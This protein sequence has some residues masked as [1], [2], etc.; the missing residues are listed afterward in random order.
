[1][2][3]HSAIGA[4]A[5]QR[6]LD[7]AHR[8]VE[9]D[10]V[11]GVRIASDATPKLAFLETALEIARWHHER[12]DGGGYPDGL[13]GNAIPIAARLMALADVY[14]ALISRRVYKEAWSL[15]KVEAT[16][17]QATNQ[18]FDPGIVEAF[19]QLAPRFAAIAR[20]YADTPITDLQHG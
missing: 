7:E 12:W 18:Q 19:A 17:L 5:I 11:S 8:I 15:E 9:A 2:R 10:I 4:N 20:H 1:M 16:I 13:A 3:Q 14:D 6:A